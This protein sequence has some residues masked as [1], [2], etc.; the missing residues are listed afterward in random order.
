MRTPFFLGSALVIL[1]AAGAASAAVTKYTVTLNGAQEVPSVDTAATGTGTLDFDN[2]TKTLTGKITYTGLSGAPTGAHIHKEA[3]GKS[4]GVAQALA[5][6]TADSVDVD[7]TLNDT[8]VT[9]L[10]AGNLYVN[11]HTNANTAGEIR[12][13]LYPESSTSKCPAEA[14][15]DA[16]SSSGETDSGTKSSSSGGTS[17]SGGSNG[18]TTVRSDAGTNTA[19]PADD[20]GCS[21][22]GSAPGSALAIAFGIGIA[23]AGVGRSRRKR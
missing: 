13:Q 20:D 17:S 7:V 6:P 15:T 9:D 16:G 23:I 21:M 19:A 3:C 8:Q 10:A 12:G 1:L 22:T 11:I 18:A 5:N 2:Q 4:G 14:E